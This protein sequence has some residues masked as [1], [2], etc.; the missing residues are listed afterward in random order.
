MNPRPRKA[1]LLQCLPDSVV[2]TRGPRA[3]R[4]L[5]LS[6]DDGPDPEYTPKLL[7][8][9][10]THDARAS[11]FLIGERAERHPRLVERLV[12]EGHLIGNH[13]YSHARFETLTLAAQLDD[14]ARTDRVLCAFDHRRLHRFRPPYGVLP[15][16]LVLHCAWRRRNIAYWSY[17]SLDYQERPAQELAGLLR[18][19]PP[20]S[21]DIVLMHDNREHT[22][23]LL[24][25]L[26]PEWREQGIAFEALPPMRS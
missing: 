4:T 6:F 9:L 3:S 5:Y 13:S 21:G 24:E 20:R 11:F 25:M 14:I 17:D 8:L 10:A 23:A 16:R 1:T 15:F 18:R 26:L 19:Q 2:V 22:I 12:A 7:D